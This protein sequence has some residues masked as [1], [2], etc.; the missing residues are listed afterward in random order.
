MARATSPLFT[1]RSMFFM[2]PTLKRDTLS[3]K[4]TLEAIN[5]HLGHQPL[6]PY[7]ICSWSWLLVIDLIFYAL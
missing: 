1:E 5:N 4:N 3:S 6:R 2:L 7:I